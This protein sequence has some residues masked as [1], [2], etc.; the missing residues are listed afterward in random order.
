[1]RKCNIQ[2][3]KLYSVYTFGEHSAGYEEFYC[4]FLKIHVMHILTASYTVLVLSLVQCDSSCCTSIWLLC[5]NSFCVRYAHNK[6]IF[7]NFIQAKPIHNY[8]FTY[9]RIRKGKKGMYNVLRFKMEELKMTGLFIVKLVKFS[10]ICIQ[11]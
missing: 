3:N 4:E 11:L 8:R 6:T 9:D 10:F 5:K 2:S 1:M 7:W